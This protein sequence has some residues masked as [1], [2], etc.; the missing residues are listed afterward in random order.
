MP[1]AW[2]SPDALQATLDFEIENE[3]EFSPAQPFDITPSDPS[4]PAFGPPLVPSS[5]ASVT[6]T[7]LPYHWLEMGELLLNAAG[8]DFSDAADVVRR[9]LRDLREVRGAKLRVNARALGTGRAMDL[10]GVGAMEV[11]EERP[12]ICVVA[13]EVRKLGALVEHTRREVEAE[14]E[15]DGR[16]G[17]D[18]LAGDVNGDSMETS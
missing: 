5:T 17:E 15:E 14:D 3:S 7:Q 18:D 1:P 6:S 10:T 8:D 13:D 4:E 11:S 12:F 9:L 16:G 2:L